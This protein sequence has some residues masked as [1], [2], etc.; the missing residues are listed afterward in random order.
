MK[1]RQD[2]IKSHPDGLK[3]CCTLKPSEL[4]KITLEHE[5]FWLY[6][7]LLNGRDTLDEEGRMRNFFDLRNLLLDMGW[8]KS[9]VLEKL[10]ADIFESKLRRRYEKEGLA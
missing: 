5:R 7:I 10:T 6:E 2:K 8:P 9:T 4:A 3:Y 1:W